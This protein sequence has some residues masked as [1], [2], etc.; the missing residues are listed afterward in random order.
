[1][2]GSLEDRFDHYIDE[3]FKEWKAARNDHERFAARQA[4]VQYLQVIRSRAELEK[5]EAAVIPLLDTFRGTDEEA[6][7]RAI[8]QLKQIVKRQ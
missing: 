4:V 6:V 7:L 1:M 8:D 2:T 5:L 3:V